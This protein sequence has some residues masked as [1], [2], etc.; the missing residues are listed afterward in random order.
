MGFFGWQELGKEQGW[1]LSLPSLTVPSG[2]ASSILLRHNS[3]I[4]RSD[5]WSEDAW[6]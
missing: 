6:W 3:S 2:T 5:S 1:L 4:A